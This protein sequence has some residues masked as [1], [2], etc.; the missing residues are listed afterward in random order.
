MRAGMRNASARITISSVVATFGRVASGGIG[1]LARMASSDRLSIGG[2]PLRASSTLW[3]S[4][5]TGIAQPALHGHPPSRRACD[6]LLIKPD[7]VPALRDVPEAD[8]LDVPHLRG[9]DVRRGACTDPHRH[10]I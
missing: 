5:S 7:F 3:I 2:V 10:R 1:T 4:V 6:V 9:H 8:R